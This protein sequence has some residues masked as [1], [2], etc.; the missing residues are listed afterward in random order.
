M[1]TWLSPAGTL[2]AA[3]VGFAVLAG[4]GWRGF[5]VLLAFFVTS[6]ALTPGGGRRTPAQV[7]ANGGVAALSALLALWRPMFLFAFLG[8]LAAAAA[9]TWSTEIGA[10]SRRDPR[11][12]T[13]LRHVPP[14]TSGGVSA[15]GSAGGL[16]GAAVVALAA[17]LT[18]LAGARPAAAVLATGTA[19]GLFD[20][21]LGATLQ[22]RW[23][24][25]ACGRMGESR[26]DGCGT[27]G[28]HVSGLP[29]LS[30][31][32]VNLA[33]TVF[34]AALAMVTAMR[35]GDPLP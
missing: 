25:P 33:A 30:N 13:T 2:S 4:T 12:I 29:F 10:R 6:S 35:L 34:G 23:R 26:T 9:D 5:V 32:G 20:S 21:L 17:L 14:G 1:R 19:A 22:A 3:A 27:P 28:Q 18:G 7:W 15:L 16:A 11:L 31:D 24:C 8:A